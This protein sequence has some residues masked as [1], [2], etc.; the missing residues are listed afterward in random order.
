M[1]TWFLKVVYLDCGRN[2][3]VLEEGLLLYQIDP[4]ELI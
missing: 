3:K 2:I 4:L 1:R